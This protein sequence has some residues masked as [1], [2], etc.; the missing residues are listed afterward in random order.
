MRRRYGGKRKLLRKRKSRKSRKSR[1]STLPSVDHSSKGLK[2]SRSIAKGIS[3]KSYTTTTIHRTGY[4]D[5]NVAGNQVYLRSNFMTP[6]AWALGLQNNVNAGNTNAFIP[7]DIFQG[8]PNL[9]GEIMRH[10]NMYRQYRVKCIRWEFVP[11]TAVVGR[12]SVLNVYTGQVN[13]GTA[14]DPV[15]GYMDRNTRA[16]SL[17]WFIKWPHK[18]GTFQDFGFNLS[19]S[20]T[21]GANTNVTTS[22][23]LIDPTT[24]RIPVTEKLVLFWKPKVMGQK[25]QNWMPLNTLSGAVPLTQAFAKSY[26]KKFPWTYI[27]DNVEQGHGNPND[28]NITGQGPTIDPSTALPYN[29]TGLRMPMT[30]PLLGIY[31]SS[32]NLFLGTADLLPFITGRWDMHVVLEFKQKYN[33]TAQQPI[34]A[35][36]FTESTNNLLDVNID[37]H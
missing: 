26:A 27:I 24:I 2:F 18:N 14:T 19:G 37:L 12:E 31:D 33:Y 23:A 4:W 6:F 28:A 1:R 15:A 7:Y 29:T 32:T 10:A 21:S 9:M 8:A 36:A 13:T 34:P 22:G 30:Q 16:A 5:G 35:T 11:T 20:G 17:M 25:V 3:R